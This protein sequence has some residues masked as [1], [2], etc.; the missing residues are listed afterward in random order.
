MIDHQSL[1]LSFCR[2]QFQAELICDLRLPRAPD[3]AQKHS[4]RCALGCGIRP[5][6]CD[7]ILSRKTGLVLNRA[8][9]VAQYEWR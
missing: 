7:V 1:H 8:P 6:D 5:L 4:A 3:R 2:L 9:R